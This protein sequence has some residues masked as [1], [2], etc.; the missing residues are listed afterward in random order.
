MC[1]IK[2]VF[3]FSST[4]KACKQACAAPFNPSVIFDLFSESFVSVYL[5]QEFMMKTASGW[6]RSTDCRS[7]S[8]VWSKRWC[9]FSWPF[10]VP[11]DL[12]AFLR[13]FTSRSVHVDSLH[14]LFTSPVRITHKWANN[15][16]PTTPSH[17]ITLVH[18]HICRHT[19]ILAILSLWGPSSP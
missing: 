5:R 15:N 6:H 9:P 4:T 18:M 1:F 3:M 13:L 2:G 8:T 19:H 16:N 12:A 7:L 11:P 17:M 14:L 10:H